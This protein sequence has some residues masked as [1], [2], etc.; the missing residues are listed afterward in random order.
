MRNGSW[1]AYRP[2]IAVTAAALATLMIGGAALALAGS[3][4]TQSTTAQS[5]M[6]QSSM[7]LSAAAQSAGAVAPLSGFADIVDSVRPAVVNIEGVREG[8]RRPDSDESEDG[9]E[10][11]GEFFERFFDEEGEGPGAEG[12]DETRESLRRWFREFQ[13]RR[14]EGEGGERHRR[15]GDRQQGMPMRAATAVADEWPG[16]PARSR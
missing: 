2:R 5:S 10:R 4:S 11:F 1:V 14:H 7:A 9:F 12:E 6:A 8:G 16:G 3:E 13:E 15:F